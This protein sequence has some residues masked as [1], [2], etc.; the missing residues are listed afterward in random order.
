MDKLLEPEIQILLNL[1]KKGR[2]KRTELSKE[3]N[4]T[5]TTLIYLILAVILL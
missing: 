1:A 3:C 2:Q 4:I 5:Y